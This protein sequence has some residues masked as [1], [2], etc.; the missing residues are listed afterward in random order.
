MSDSTKLMWRTL[1]VVAYTLVVGWLYYGVFYMIN[2]LGNI[3]WDDPLLYVSSLL[4]FAL[5]NPISLIYLVY[6]Y[7]AIHGAFYEYRMAKAK[8]SSR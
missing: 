8:E 3:G 7:F 5:V 1:G 2:S 4:V 6:P